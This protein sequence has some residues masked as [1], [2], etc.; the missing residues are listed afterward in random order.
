MADLIRWENDLIASMMNVRYALDA[1]EAP[2]EVDY[3][4]IR[5]AAEAFIVRAEE[6]RK[7]QIKEEEEYVR[8]RDQE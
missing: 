8:E 5:Q 3:R 4:I 7:Q 6:I 2:R 1:F